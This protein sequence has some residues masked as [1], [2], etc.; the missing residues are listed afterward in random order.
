MVGMVSPGKHTVAF[1]V[2]GAGRPRKVYSLAPG[3]LDDVDSRAEADHLRDHYWKTHG[4]PVV[5]TR[6]TNNFGFYQFPE[7]LIPLVITNAM[8]NMRKKG[9]KFLP[10]KRVV[11]FDDGDFHSRV[12]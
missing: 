4:T 12:S 9:A 5:I 11:E 6:C 3:S 2:G 8:E 10:G 1:K 7:K